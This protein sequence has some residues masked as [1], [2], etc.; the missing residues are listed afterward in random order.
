M[1]TA[2]TPASRIVARSRCRSGA[3]G[4]VR[5][6]GT[7]RPSTR[8]PVVPTTPGRSPAART[9]RLQ[10]VGGRRLAV[11]ARDPHHG[12]ADAG[13]A[14]H[15]GRRSGPIARR[16]DGTLPGR[17]R[18]R[19]IARRPARRRRPRSP[20]GR[21]IVAVDR[22]PGD[23]EEERPGRDVAGVEGDVADDARR[24]GPRP[25]GTA[26]EHVGEQSWGKDGDHRLVAYPRSRPRPRNDHGSPWACGGGRP[27]AAAGIAS[28]WIAYRA[29]SGT[30]ARR[31]P[32]RRRSG[33]HRSRRRSPPCGSDAGRN[34]TNEAM[35][36]W[37]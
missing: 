33:V 22:C 30:T 16:T 21:E 9:I 35:Y 10:Q 31:P 25:S 11:R 19:A 3:S 29:I 6:S 23:A 12:H 7:G 34:P 17:R 20:A 32:R 28:R 4:V 5:T 24:L 37:T 14:E 36:R 26:S 13:C 18:G 15:H 1:A 2:S 27:G 8:A